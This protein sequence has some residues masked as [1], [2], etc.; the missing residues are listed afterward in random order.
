MFHIQKPLQ[1]P[2]PPK[3]EK[4][5]DDKHGGKD[6]ALTRAWIFSSHTTFFS[7]MHT[8]EPGGVSS[9]HVDF[10]VTRRCLFFLLH[11]GPSA[12]HRIPS[13]DHF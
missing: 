5:D 13:P 7:F 6:T 9:S 3:T 10:Q 4:N 2:A 12:L 11:T 1:T 8:D